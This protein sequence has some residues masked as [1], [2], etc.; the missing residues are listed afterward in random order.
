MVYILPPVMCE[1]GAVR[2]VNDSDETVSVVS[3]RVEICQNNTWGAVCDDNWS[4]RDTAV[5]CKQLG[6]SQRESTKQ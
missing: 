6:F 3:G 5:V 2:L 1:N 4:D